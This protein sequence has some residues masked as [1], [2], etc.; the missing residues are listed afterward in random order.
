MAPPPP[1]QWSGSSEDVWGLFVYNLENKLSDDSNMRGVLNQYDAILTQWSPRTFNERMQWAS[2]NGI[3]VMYQAA[4]SGWFREDAGWT[5]GPNGSRLNLSKWREGVVDRYVN[6]G[7]DFDYWTQEGTLLGIYM[8]DEPMAENSWGSAIPGRTLDVD[9][10]GYLNSF[11]PKTRTYVRA[12]PSILPKMQYQY[13]DGGW[14]QWTWV[15][16]FSWNP[17]KYQGV[18]WWVSNE[19]AAADA[20]GF[21]RDNLVWGMA[22]QHGG[23]PNDQSGWGLPTYGPSYTG[24]GQ[25]GT[26]MRP[27][28]I[29]QVA[30]AVQSAPGIGAFIFRYDTTDWFKRLPNDFETQWHNALTTAANNAN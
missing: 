1:V 24:S 20:R 14:S 16:G 4:G 13:L 21:D 25:G 23:Q 9:M 17:K 19:L 22:V 15:K 27:E 7:V 28:E 5:N 30:Q 18:D 10:A 8:I 6:A 3:K 2:D 12:A 11:F 29:L 26:Y